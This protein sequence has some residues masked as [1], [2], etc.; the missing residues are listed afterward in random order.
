MTGSEFGV[1]AL[2]VAIIGSGAYMVGAEQARR[3]EQ[4]RR[5]RTHAAKL[6]RILEKEEAKGRL[7]SGS[8][9]RR[10]RLKAG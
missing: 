9:E 8:V 4:R 10:R 6:R 7:Y 3:E 1:T 5:D 2:V